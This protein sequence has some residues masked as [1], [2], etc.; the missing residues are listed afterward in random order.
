MAYRD[1]VSALA[2]KYG[3]SNNPGLLESSLNIKG[4][5]FTT[6]DSSLIPVEATDMNR[7]GRLFLE[8]YALSSRRE[9]TLTIDEAFLVKA[10][11]YFAELW[12]PNPEPGKRK[13]LDAMRVSKSVT[14]IWK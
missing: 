3:L 5:L 7:G 10:R 1:N 9:E 13:L 2:K 11:E 6:K 8:D 4:L 12:E 14:I